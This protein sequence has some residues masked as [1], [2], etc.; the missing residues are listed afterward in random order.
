[1]RGAL[2]GA[3]LDGVMTVF[4]NAPCTEEELEDAENGIENGCDPA[5]EL[6]DRSG[7]SAPNTPDRSSRT[8][9]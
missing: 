3:I 5:T 8:T 1:L 4:P 6:I 2:S 9:S 7:Q